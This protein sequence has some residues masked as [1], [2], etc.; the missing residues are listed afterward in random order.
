MKIRTLDTRSRTLTARAV[1][2]V[3]ALAILVHAIPA[4]VYAQRSVTKKYPAQ[5]NV[6]LEVRNISGTITVE[7]WDKNEISVTAKLFTPNAQFTP[8]QTPNCIGIDIV[9]DNRGRMVGDINFTVKVPVDSTVDIETKRG[10]IS[11]NNVRGGMVRARVS[12]SGDIELTGI[13]ASEVI[14]ENGVG[15][16]VFDGELVA[17]GSY[18]FK[19]LS[20]NIN[21]NIPRN[22]SFS[23]VASAQPQ[24]INL[25]S[26][27]SPQLSIV[28]DGRK[29]YGDVGG[30]GGRLPS[31]TV[32]NQRGRIS[33]IAR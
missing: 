21:I 17:G 18:T 4:D 19:S 9:R 6:R 26:F 20:G 2:T 14:A 1:L 32:F 8:E 24:S 28:A 30:G 31:L 13:R 27:A 23:L 29:V 16:M 3:I 22:S 10:N 7:A 15:D 25:N 11:I 5:K 33:F 12:T